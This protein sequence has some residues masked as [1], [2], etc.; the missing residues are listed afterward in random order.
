MKDENWDDLRLF[1]QVAREGGL[2]GAAEK[3]GL[4]APTIGRRMLALERATGHHL[5]IRHSKGYSLAPD[6]EV[7]LAHVRAMD[8]QASF[9]RQW[10]ENG[11][12]LPIVS[13][14]SDGWMSAFLARN[15]GAI[16]TPDDPFRLCVKATET[17]VDLI[18][19]EA[20]I[21]LTL[22]RPASG[23]LAARQ[24][25]RINHAV[26]ATASVAAEPQERWISIGREQA[27][28][29]ADRYISRQPDKWISVWTTT[30]PTLLE[31]A[32]SGA[33]RAVLPCF[34]GDSEPGLVRVGD[35]I[36]DL[37]ADLWIAMHDDD[38]NR[39][40]VRMVIDRLAALFRR[41]ALL[42]EGM[43]RAEPAQ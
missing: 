23:N 26:Y 32:R 2:V 13:V 39:G 20:E 7:L 36:S 17:G 21:A 31:L 33:G 25:V 28:T 12:C 19:R 43:A 35:C 16:W 5:F 6:G 22:Q 24:S 30:T 9:I 14:A 18:F 3:T 1:L 38:R 8:A 41:E 29:L 40:E 15:L 34:I 27:S 42:F 37:S 11:Y 4:S 10:N